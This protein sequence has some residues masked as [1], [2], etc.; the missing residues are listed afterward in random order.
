MASAAEE[1][2][3][4]E[5]GAGAETSAAASGASDGGAAD[6][7]GA[8]ASPGSKRISPIPPEDVVELFN[9]LDKAVRAR[10]LYQDNNPVYRGFLKALHESVAHVFEQGASLSVQVEEGGFRWYGQLLQTG[11]GRDNLAFLFY[12]DG[13]RQLSFLAGFEE[14]L[15]R[16]LAVVHRAR[17][18]DQHRDDDMVTLLWEEEFTCFQYS[19]IDALAEGLTLPDGDQPPITDSAGKPIEVDPATIQHEIDVG[20]PVEEQAPAVRA[21]MPSVASSITR[22]DF[23]ETLYF[24]EDEEMQTLQSEVGKEWTRDTKKDVLN[25]LFDRLEDPV[26]EWQ[27]EILRILRQ[28]LPAFLSRGDLR[29]AAYILTELNSVAN[30]A[31]LTDNARNETDRLFAELSEPEVLSQLLRSFEEGAIQ[32]EPV[33]LG[34]FLAHLGP[35]ALPILL[36]GVHTTTAPGLQARLQQAVETLARDHQAEVVRLVGS[37]EAA[38]AA[39]ATRLAG[40]IG[41]AEAVP[42][43]VAFYGRAGDDLRRTAVE[44]L[45][46]IRSAPAL[47]ALQDAIEDEDRDVRLTAL[48]GLAALRYLPARARLEKALEGK[49]V[50]DADLTEKMAFFEA[51]GV[52]ATADNIEMLDRLLNGRKLFSRSSPELRACAALAL[53]KINAPA[54]RTAL[55]RAA[56]DP[57]PIVRNAVLKALRRDGGTAA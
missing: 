7:N 13:V 10:R 34:V 50:R 12:K 40:K 11:A 41:I 39:G 38:V 27:D 9:A 52:V 53:G 45:I 51:F 22:E 54:A 6:G 20:D 5:S 1:P 36:H 35:R 3:G 26:P 21:G 2:L 49:I 32:A 8:P 43:I 44:A 33:E 19:Y 46:N 31:Q 17:G 57:Q 29:S 48:R 28:L 25:A 42:G 47:D 56:D 30:T 14:E 15:D 55:E 4:A 16:F 23:A 37:E 18:A 24:L